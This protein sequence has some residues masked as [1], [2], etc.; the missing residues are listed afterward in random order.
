[1]GVGLVKACIEVL[2]AAWQGEKYLPEQIDSLNRQLDRDFT[3]LCR[4]DGSTDGTL[5]LLRAECARN[6]RFRL[7]EDEAGR[8]GAAGSFFR[9]LA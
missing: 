8:L 4:D 6:T 7:L 2:L 5:P 3:V 9:L 1:M